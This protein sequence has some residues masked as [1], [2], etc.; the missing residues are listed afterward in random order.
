[1]KLLHGPDSKVEI[2][3]LHKL[4]DRVGRTPWSSISWS[5]NGDYIIAGDHVLF[6]ESVTVLT[7]DH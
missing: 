3:T 5:G 2:D 7:M 1:M 4:Q 6:R